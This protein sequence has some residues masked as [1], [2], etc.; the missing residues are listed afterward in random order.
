MFHTM[1]VYAR[2]KNQDGNIN[3]GIS[4]YSGNGTAYPMVTN[5]AATNIHYGQTFFVVTKMAM[6]GNAYYPARPR[7]PVRNQRFVGHTRYQYLWRE[8]TAASQRVRG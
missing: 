3:L 5:W 8:R 6:R 4:K 7:Q 2:D 1:L